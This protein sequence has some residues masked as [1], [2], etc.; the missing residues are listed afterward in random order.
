[1]KALLT[2]VVAVLS[3][4]APAQQQIV[5]RNGERIDIHFRSIRHDY[6]T[7]TIG[8]KKMVRVCHY[9]DLTRLIISEDSVVTFSR[10]LEDTIHFLKDDPIVGRV[11]LI[12]DR[13]LSYL[14]YENAASARV[15]L[16]DVMNVRY[17]NGELESFNPPPILREAFR[18]SGFYVDWCAGYA[19]GNVISGVETANYYEEAYKE[20]QGSSGFAGVQVGNNFQIKKK[21]KISRFSVNAKWLGFD[22]LAGGPYS[23]WV[24][25]PL[26]PGFSYMHPLKNQKKSFGLSLNAGPVILI[27]GGHNEHSV[28]GLTARLSAKFRMNKLA[29]GLF[30]GAA[31]GEKKLG[32][33]KFYKQVFTAGLS[34]GIQL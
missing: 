4:T 17:K 19:Y 3:F 1:M 26:N 32:S 30:I 21:D 31:H 10:I 12:D 11:T 27:G 7:Y 23:L 16:E 22:I 28:L 8:D 5:F 33:F 9:R 24:L 18:K 14:L 15:L 6:L 20:N 13:F 29:L 2:V 25:T 34:V